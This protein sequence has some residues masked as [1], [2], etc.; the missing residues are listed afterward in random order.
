MLSAVVML[1]SATA[2]CTADADRSVGAARSPAGAV[3]HGEVDGHGD[4][5]GTVRQF[6]LEELSRWPAVVRVVIDAVDVDV[7]SA[8]GP[9]SGVQGLCEATVLEAITGD[10]A[11][12][13]PVT[14]TCSARGRQGGLSDAQAADAYGLPALAPAPGTQVA[15]ALAPLPGA[16]D[17]WATRIV[18]LGGMPSSVEA[19]S[20]PSPASRISLAVPGGTQTMSVAEFRALAA[21]PV[22]G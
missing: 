13:A 20:A 12:G 3:A 18:S 10:I 1:S 8:G 7:W 2:A 6:S 11:P 17:R 16:V 15:Y 4:G 5:L 14:V 21:E 19:G 9:A 22:A